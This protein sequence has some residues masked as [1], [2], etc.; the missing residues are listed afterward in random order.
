ML[1]VSRKVG[2]WDIEW[3]QW[4]WFQT[5]DELLLFQLDHDNAQARRFS[6]DAGYSFTGEV[7]YG[8]L[9]TRFP[10]FQIDVE[11][12][13][14]GL[15]VLSQAQQP[16]Q[17]EMDRIFEIPT[18]TLDEYRCNTFRQAT[19]WAFQ[20]SFCELTN[21][22]IMHFTQALELTGVDAVSDGSPKAERGAAAWIITY[23]T[24]HL[25]GGFRIPSPPDAQD[26]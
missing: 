21:D 25:A 9:M 11:E 18:L 17:W 14:D 16:M 3:M 12:T 8:E 1:A 19:A 26:S 10:L 23:G 15:R 24:N 2:R 22:N 4:E 13:A 7:H 6:W 5:E 20:Y